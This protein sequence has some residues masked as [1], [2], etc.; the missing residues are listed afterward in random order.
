MKVR[1]SA[2]AGAFYPQDKFEL[3]EMVEN[4]LSAAPLYKLDNIRAAVSPHAG[5]I[6][7][8][9]VAA[10]TYKQFLNLDLNKNWTIF[11]LGP[12]HYAYFSGASM[13]VFDFY[14][15]PLGLVKVSS[16]ARAII[17]EEGF[18]FVIDAHVE[19][20]CLEVQLP[21]LQIVF[22]KFEIVPIVFSEIS[23]KYLALVLDKYLNENSILLVSSDL[24]HYHPYDIARSIDKHC[25]IAVD[26]LDISEL[27][28]CEACG[29]IGI[30]T[31]IYLAQKNKWR[32]KVLAYATSG[33]T[34]GPKNQVVGY[35]SYIFY[36]GGV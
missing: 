33:D 12:S 30:A 25:N 28:R 17:E 31:S 27:E 22:P 18:S 26:K 14:E 13:G 4:F 3:K 5:Y 32:S 2:V 8:G 29:K 1:R 36:E 6:F 11:L 15:T 34:A 16:V 35:G 19:E 20:H 7:S 21:F 24:S 9:P 10:Y 23:Y